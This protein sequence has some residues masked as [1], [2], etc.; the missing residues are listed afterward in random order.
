MAVPRRKHS[1]ARQA[2]RRAQW[3]GTLVQLASCSQCGSAVRPHTVCLNC[4]YYK[5]KQVLV[6][7]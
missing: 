7:R 5:G 1:R 2:K 3:K 4:G 6:I